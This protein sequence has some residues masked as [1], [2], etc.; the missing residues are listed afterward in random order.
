M[1]E[2]NL[3][4]KMAEKRLNQKQLSEITGIRAATISAYYNN[5]AKHF[6]LDHLDKFCEIFN[7]SPNDIIKYKK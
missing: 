5:S 2:L 6:V 3:H 1:I 4:V 7:C